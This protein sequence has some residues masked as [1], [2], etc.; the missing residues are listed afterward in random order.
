MNTTAH[1]IEMNIHPASA[2]C[3][4]IGSLGTTRNSIGKKL[5]QILQCADIVQHSVFDFTAFPIAFHDLVVLMPLGDGLGKIAHSAHNLS[6]AM[7]YNRFL[8]FAMLNSVNIAKKTMK[9]TNASSCTDRLSGL[10]TLPVWNRLSEKSRSFLVT[11]DYTYENMI[12]QDSREEF[13]YSGVCLLVTKAVEVESCNRFFN[14]Y[15][16]YLVEKLGRNVDSWPDAMTK[17]DRFGGKYAARDFT[18]GSVVHITGYDKEMNDVSFLDYASSVLYQ[19]KEA[20]WIKNQLKSACEFVEKVR[21]DYRNPASHKESI[22][23]VTAAECLD[24]VINV[25][26]KLKEMIV[27]MNH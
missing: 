9:E 6:F 10:F 20:I 7:F 22:K 14:E 16:A 11:A 26:K 27:Y 17:T 24:Y 15:K 25:Q 2:L 5:V 13:D 4:L 18:L 21:K 1:R 8:Y 19:G 3:L 12:Q 23:M